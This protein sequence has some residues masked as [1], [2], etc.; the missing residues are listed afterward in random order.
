MSAT[1]DLVEEYQEYWDLMFCHGCE[2][3]ALS[4]AAWLRT[5]T[6]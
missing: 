3:I 2:C 6:V 1:E 4:F 5:L